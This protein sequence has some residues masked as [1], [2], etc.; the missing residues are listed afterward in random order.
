MASTSL[1]PV[2]A[3]SFR[4]PLG[5]ASDTCTKSNPSCWGIL[6]TSKWI[7]PSKK[8]LPLSVVRVSVDVLEGFVEDTFCEVSLV[9]LQK[10]RPCRP[11]LPSPGTTTT[12]K[13]LLP[14]SPSSPPHTR[15]RRSLALV[16]VAAENSERFRS[17]SRPAAF[18]YSMSRMLSRS[19][20]SSSTV[21]PRGNSFS[22]V[23]GSNTNWAVMACFSSC[24]RP[25]LWVSTLPWRASS[26]SSPPPMP[27]GPF[28][29]SS[30]IIGFNKSS[31]SFFGVLMLSFGEVPIAEKAVFPISLW[32]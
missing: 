16:A 31:Q 27:L 1:S 19:A 23:S 25:S 21:S 5:T 6:R 28:A 2:L 24:L 15:R 30:R 17:A 12:P 26:S 22:S 11:R 9:A 13:S 7:W 32:R 14:S 8:P 4:P 20:A 3:L 29:V 10:T 18:E